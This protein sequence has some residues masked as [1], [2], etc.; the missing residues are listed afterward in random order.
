MS[1][2]NRSGVVNTVTVVRFTELISCPKLIL[3]T[4][5]LGV[6]A[7]FLLVIIIN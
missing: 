6:S 4:D 2:D 3:F 7:E 1:L 5:V